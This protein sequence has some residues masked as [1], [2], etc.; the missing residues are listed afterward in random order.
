MNDLL[1]CLDEPFAG[2]TDDFV[3]YLKGRLED[4]AKRHNVLLVTNDHVDAM[5]KLA[6]NTIVVSAID[7]STVTINET[8]KVDR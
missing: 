4:M 5:R 1:L 7:R 2:V 8:A 6:K 3:P